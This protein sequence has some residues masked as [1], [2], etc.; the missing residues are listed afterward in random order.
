MKK[1]TLQ[2]IAD[3]LNISR[4][5]VSKVINN[6][7][8]VSLE[9]KKKVAQKLVEH[10]YKKIDDSL[11]NLLEDP[12]SEEIKCIAVVA[13]APE[14]SEFWL[15]IINSIANALTETGYDFIY[16][17]LS[18]N[19][20][21]Q[22]VLPKMIDAKHVNGVIVINVY[23]DMAIQ[24]LYQT[25]IPTIFLDITPQMYTENIKGDIV[26]LDGSR[27]IFEITNHIISQGRTEIGFIGDITYS[28]TIL[29]RWEG[30]KRAMTA[31]GLS[32]H[33]KFCFTSSSYGHFYYKEE[34]ENFLND[35]KVLP[36]AF[37][38]ANDFIAFMLIDYLKKRGYRIPEDI[39]V[40]GYDDIREKITAESK[41][42]T[43]TID[44]DIL[45][46]RLV[47]QVLMRIETPNMPNEIIYIEP[48]VVYR[49]STDF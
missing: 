2:E 14:F 36:Q 12:Q 8:G 6:K 39:A 37:V 49:D 34:I 13:I 7:P 15:K 30:F 22:F 19:E 18:R 16:S 29:E 3:H 26:L 32:I 1:T 44:T 31:N 5:T 17:F 33:N 43:V 48:N 40:S 20:E 47:K 46:K 9:M 4:I 25:G 28:K 24:T 27:S 45:G 38:C 42:T 23:D 10:G 41:L 35:V 21:N 11:L